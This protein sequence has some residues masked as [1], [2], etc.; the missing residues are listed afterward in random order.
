[1][2]STLKDVAL[3]AG[4]SKST[5]SQYLHQR[6]HYMSEETKKKIQLAIEELDY[7]PNEVARSLKQ[8]KTFIVGVVSS[9]I[10]SK[11]TTEVVRAIEDECQL[12]GIQV[13]VCNTDDDPLKENKYVQSMIAR[14]VDGLIIFPTE[15]NRKL[16]QSMLKS[17]YPFVFI[18][19]KID[20]I[21]VDTV[22]LD[23]ELASSLAVQSL[24]ERGH[25]RIG[26][27]TFP[28]GQKAI[29]TRSER[30]QGYRQTLQNSGI[31]V[32][33]AY[34]KSGRLDEMQ[35]LI[36][37]LF[38]LSPPPSAIVATNDMILEQ[39]LIYAKNQSLS[40]PR[41]FS[42]IGIDDVSFA[43][44]Y[45]PPITTVSQPSFEIGKRSAQL[46]LRQ[47]DRKEHEPRRAAE[48][49]RLSPALNPRESVQN[50]NEQD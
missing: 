40:I 18:D 9:T 47:I 31:E 37:E 50:A 35:T 22:L 39:V 24:V 41:D 17:G 14:Q 20:G 28:L 21:D 36:G 33:E 19:R 48:I 25:T 49:F 23:N 1:M 32:D 30:L 10:L 46:L 38:R 12:K 44:F 13:I 2:P 8:K 42:L 3:R 26:I 11:F 45:T 5:V 43:S 6:Y 15:Q 7:I 29:T 4:V 16:Y 27:L 34:V